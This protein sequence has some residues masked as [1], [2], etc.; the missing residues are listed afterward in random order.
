M[1]L[2]R[3]DTADAGVPI[4]DGVPHPDLLHH[5]YP[6]GIATVPSVMRLPPMQ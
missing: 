6:E 2:P 3:P 1:K 5:P 4:R